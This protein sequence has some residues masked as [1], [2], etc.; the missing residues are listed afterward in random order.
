MILSSLVIEW[1]D[2]R[3][4]KGGDFSILLSGI[5]IQTILGGGHV[6]FQKKFMNFNFGF[7]CLTRFLSVLPSQLLLGFLT[8]IL[9]MKI[10]TL[11][12]E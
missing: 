12:A 7:C 4:L 5:C 6:I 1:Y 3:K 11:K 10:P 9:V 8:R 2:W